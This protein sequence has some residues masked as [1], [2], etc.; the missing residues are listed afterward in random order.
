MPERP[1]L[2]TGAAGG[3]GRA[4]VARAHSPAVL[5]LTHDQLDITDAEAV[6]R[7]FD[8]LRPPAVI[9]AAA[10]TAVDAAELDPVP[11]GSSVLRSPPVRSRPSSRTAGRSATS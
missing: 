5:G 3:I 6:G 8:R 9:N 7:V 10:F 4:V 1:I 11:A 2:V